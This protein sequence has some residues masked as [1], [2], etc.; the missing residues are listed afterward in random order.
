MRLITNLA[1]AIRKTIF[2]EKPD[3]RKSAETLEEAISN[4]TEIDGET[5]LSLAPESMASVIQVT[6]TDPRVC[7]YIAHTLLLESEYLQQ[8]GEAE[9]SQVRA[10]QARAL[11][12]AY[13][14]D[15]EINDA[16]I[17]DL[18]N[19]YAGEDGDADAEGGAAGGTSGGLGAC[20]DDEDK[21]LDARTEVAED[22]KDTYVEQSPLP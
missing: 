15:L 4:A 19:R 17:N 12:K 11:A 6:G 18:V 20:L 22:I 1:E 14:V 3:P 8:A 7:G 9:L 2:D 5:L 21:D 16:V 13:D 10:E